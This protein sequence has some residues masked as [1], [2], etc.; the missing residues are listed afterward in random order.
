MASKSKVSAKYRD[1]TQP[2]LAYIY[3]HCLVN[4]H[5]GH[6]LTRREQRQTDQKQPWV[7]YWLD[8]PALP[9]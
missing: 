1:V 4:L 2:G 6:E 8:L 9:P 3:S 7:E 5:Y